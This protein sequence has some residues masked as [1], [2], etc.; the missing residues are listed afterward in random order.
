VDTIGKITLSG[1][2]PEQI[3]DQASVL[4]SAPLRDLAAQLAADADLTVSVI[5]HQDGR[6]ELEVLRTGPPGHDEAT[7]DCRRFTRQ[8]PAA[9]ART[10]P[11]AGPA[12]LR[13]A[14]SLVRSIL[15]G[16]AAT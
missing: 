16:T 4:A 11:I 5:T 15:G 14:A 9:S 12:D 7:I 8:P 10:L 6:Q 1:M 13:D 3:R 2:T